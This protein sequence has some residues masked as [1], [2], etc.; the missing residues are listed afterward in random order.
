MRE[1]LRLFL[2]RRAVDAIAREWNEGGLEKKE[3]MRRLGLIARPNE[4]GEPV[5][6]L[7][8]ARRVRP[9]WNEDKE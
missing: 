9:A 5:M 3:R 8:S 4:Y 7:I 2:L 1:R 6:E